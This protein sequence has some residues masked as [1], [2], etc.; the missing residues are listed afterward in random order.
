[1]TDVMSRSTS[2]AR[3]DMVLMTMFA[4]C[5][6]V[7]AAIGIY[8]LIAYSVQHRTQEIGIRLALG[9]LSRDVRNMVVV[10]GMRLALIGVVIG[11]VASVALTRVVSGFLF[12]V[13]PH[14]PAVFVV[15]PLLLSVVAL[16]AVWLPARRAAR[17]DPLVALRYE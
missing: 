7:L 14:D 4:L 2:R 5:A 8:R 10:Q 9:A 17:V 15:I 12:G 6:L 1:M 13:E 3:F 16:L 11:V